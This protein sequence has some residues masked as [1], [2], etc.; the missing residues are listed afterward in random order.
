MAEEKEKYKARSEY[1]EFVKVVEG[2]E[3]RVYTDAAGHLTIGY[4]HKLTPKEK[5]SKKFIDGLSETDAAE[6]LEEDIEVAYRMSRQQFANMFGEYESGA[7][8]SLDYGPWNTLSENQKMMITDYGFNLG[9]IR[10]YP[11]LMLALLEQDWGTV[12][13]EYERTVGGKKLGRNVDLYDQYIAPNLDPASS[14]GTVER[15]LNY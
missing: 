2:F 12:S 10:S 8:S 14:A 5:A 9:S 15:T 1:I 11:T 4:G 7:D 6:I 3:P 13:K